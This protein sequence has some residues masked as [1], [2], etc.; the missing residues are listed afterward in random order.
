MSQ[1]KPN[2]VLIVVLASVAGVLA[3]CVVLGIIGAIV[4]GN[5]KPAAVPTPAAITTADAS[6]QPAP[7]TAAPASRAAGAATTAAASPARIPPTPNAE[8]WAAYIAAL[9][10]IDPDIVHGKEEKAVDRG[11]DQCGSV[12][13]WPN[14]QAK[15]V[16]LTNKRFIGPTHPQGFGTA[17]AEQ[18]LA[19]VRKYICPTY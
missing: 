15:L 16:N 11:R 3:L 19:A 5:D 17:K 14:D 2:R 9:K 7:T 18:I 4:G 8:T 12:K 6:T 1:K 13:D 10:R